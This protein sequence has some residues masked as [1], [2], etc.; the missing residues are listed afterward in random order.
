MHRKGHTI[1]ASN[2]PPKQRK[3]ERSRNGAGQQRTPV[4]HQGHSRWQRSGVRFA[5]ELAAVG[6]PPLLPTPPAG[7]GHPCPLGKF[8]LMSFH[9][10]QHN[11]ANLSSPRAHRGTTQM[12]AS[13]EKWAPA[14]RPL[15]SA[16]GVAS[17]SSSLSNGVRPP[18]L[19]LQRC[20]TS[21]FPFSPVTL[22]TV[23]VH[24]H[25]MTCQ[26]RQLHH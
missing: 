26:Q 7:R 18:P 3:H 10:G 19:S 21:L 14:T 5:Q 9:M 23:V 24:C 12:P 13:I 4:A 17:H 11:R 22:R 8:F 25:S 15:I 16:S 2:T 1:D 6:R 20:L